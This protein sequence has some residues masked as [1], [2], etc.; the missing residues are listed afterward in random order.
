[1][2]YP[3]P[4]E[5]L[6]EDGTIDLSKAYDANI[7][8]WDKVAINF[9]YREFPKGA[10]EAPRA[11]EDPHRRV[12]QDLRYFTNQDTDIHPRVEQWSNGAD[13]GVELT[14][15]MKV[16]RAALNR[17][18][19]NTIRTG[20]PTVMIE[21]PLVPIYMYHRYAV[22]GTASM[23]AGQDFTYAM[24]DDNT[25]PVEWVKGEC[26]ARRSTR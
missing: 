4:L 6:N 19:L 9:G 26:S 12:G 14:R 25:T 18:G 17:I 11:D 16:R 5:V 7:G 1:M 10:N 23:I 24:R 2:D 21:E 8:D 22:E 13:Q 3:H 15:L 20:T